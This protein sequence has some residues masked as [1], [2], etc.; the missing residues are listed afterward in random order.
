MF[1]LGILF[2]LSFLIIMDKSFTIGVGLDTRDNQI[3][4]DLVY[5]AESR[6]KIII[7]A[8]IKVQ[9]AQETLHDWMQKCLRQELVGLS[10]YKD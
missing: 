2:F 4:Q 5:Y 3:I 9:N 8:I 1:F 7:L 6:F 10:Y